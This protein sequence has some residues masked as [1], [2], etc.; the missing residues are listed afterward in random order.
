MGNKEY[1]FCQNSNNFCQIFPM[2]KNII[3]KSISLP[4]RNFDIKNSSTYSTMMNNHFPDFSQIEN[5]GKIDINN[6]NNSNVKSF[7]SQNYKSKKFI[8]L[9]PKLKNN[10]LKLNNTSKTV[11]RNLGNNKKNISY[12]KNNSTNLINKKKVFFIADMKHNIKSVNNNI[13]KIDDINEIMGSLDKNKEE[14]NEVKK[15]ENTLTEEEEDT[16]INN[17]ITEN[18]NNSNNSSLNTNDIKSSQKNEKSVDDEKINNK[19]LEEKKIRNEIESISE[20]KEMKESNE[21]SGKNENILSEKEIELYE[22]SNLNKKSNDKHKS[23]SIKGIKINNFRSSINPKNKSCFESRNE[24]LSITNCIREKEVKIINKNIDSKDNSHPLNFLIK[25][26]KIK[27]SKY[28]L[29][30]NSFNILT[31]EEDNSIQY[32]LFKDGMPNGITKFVIDKENKIY[33]KGEYENGYPKG[34]GRYST[35]KKGS[36]YEGIWD[37]QLL[38][39]I[40][41]WKDGSLYMGEFKNN[42][43]DGLGLHRWQDGT[44]Y[45]GEWKNDTM[46]GFCN[47]K[48]IDDRVYEG[49]MKNGLKN[50]YGE[51]TWKPIRK[52]IGY[53]INDVKEG[54][55][56]YVWNIKTF[57]I[58]AGF[59]HEGKIEGLGMVINGK[60]AHYGVWSYG[61][62]IESFKNIRELELKFKSTENNMGKK[63]IRRRS[64]I[65]EDINNLNDSNAQNFDK[66][67][68]KKKIVYQ[69]KNELQGFINFMCQD[70]RVIKNFII[71]AY[72]KSNE[73]K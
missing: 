66:K 49:Q 22:N 10:T 62:K 3:R 44:I 18:T 63:L 46:E 30:N 7:Q 4:K 61:E 38:L 19:N 51:F 29:N 60:D 50:G 25:K 32:S 36:F 24:F 1:S 71:N 27:T 8:L 42:K 43:K 40:E 73:K 9:N 31:Y 59:W 65:L 13:N 20:I 6:T 37:K 26:R 52:Y 15:K 45:Y 2:E 69:A 70:I 54:F 34:Y 23:S 41:T 16:I 33:F 17:S 28:P 5:G 48:F 72:Y 64:T 21:F 58:F 67:E 55:G 12:D 14:N 11:L 68:N 39:G 53:Y 56:I 35:G 57:K 47:I